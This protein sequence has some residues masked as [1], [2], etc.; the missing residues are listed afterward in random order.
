MFLQQ[1]QIL[2]L[3]GFLAM[4]LALILDVRNYVK[5]LGLANCKSALAIL[6]LEGTQLW[7]LFMKPL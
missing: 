2:F 1:F 7:K 4:M 3:K 6:P 5:D